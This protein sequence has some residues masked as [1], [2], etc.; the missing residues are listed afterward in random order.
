MGLIFKDSGNKPVDP[1]IARKRA[2]LFSLP[3]AAMG[4]FALILLLHDGL[5]GGV[6][7]RKLFR[8][9]GVIAAS[10][11]F[12]ALIFGIVGKKTSLAAQLKLSDQ[13]AEKPWLKRADWA[14]GKIKSAG[15]PHAKS[16]LTMGVALCVIGGIIAALVIPKALRDG[17]YNALVALLFPI[18]GIAF[19]ISVIKKILAHRR[20]GDCIFEMTQTPAPIGGSLAG[21]IQ[22]GKP[23]KF[24]NELS[25]ELFCVRKMTSGAGQNRRTEEK[26]L[27]QGQKIFNSDSPEMAAGKIPVQFDLPPGQ[28]QCSER[29][30]EAICWR[31]E[32]KIPGE[33]FHATF[34]APV[35]KIVIAPAA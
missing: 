5:L 23:L 3:F 24:A 32:M 29:G 25:V 2:I 6:D 28:P 35:F 19:L 15:I 1:A 13:L 31:L 7:R 14:A 16:Y 33:N 18:V 10:V 17:N 9:L 26:I 30:S 20:F 27:W 11:G 34:D 21:A 4:L 8:L 22:T 12:V